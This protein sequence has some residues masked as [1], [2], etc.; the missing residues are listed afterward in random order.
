M[1]TACGVVMLPRMQTS[2][3]FPRLNW[4]PLLALLLMTGQSGAQERRVLHHFKPAD[5][6]LGDVHPFV[7]DG[8][9]FLYYLKPGT[10]DSALVRS[11]DWLH[12]TGGELTHSSTTPEDWMSPYYVL[13]VFHDPAA[14]V[15]RSFYGHS[16]GRM[17]S[18][19]SADLL[20]WS[21]APREYHIPP[22]DYYQRRRDP[23]VFWIPQTREYGCVMTTWMKGRPKETAGAVSLAVSPDLKQW[24]DIGP[25][26]DPGDIGEPECPQMFLLGG[27][28]Y[29]LASIYDRAVGAPVYWSSERPE[30][31]WNRK[32]TGALDGKDL[33]AA[34]I[35]MEGELPV[36]FGW[37]P[38]TASRPGRQPWGGHLALP[39]VV[40]SLGDGA[41][42]TR[43]P[44]RLARVFDKLPWQLRDDIVITHASHAVLGQW[45]NLA[46]E[47]MLEFATSETTVK[48][49]IPPLG[50]VVLHTSRLAVL[51][52][53]GECWS[54][55]PVVL[56]AGKPVTVQ[57]FVDGDIVELFVADRYSLAARLPGQKGGLR[58][59]MDAAGPQAKARGLRV[60]EW[61]EPR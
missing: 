1:S 55:L 39:R 34:Q 35:A 14:K 22:A 43:L 3:T 38:A 54:E 36:L 20:H 51:D 23:F 4:L 19:F 61:L 44:E 60:S 16:Q 59:V 56:P 6:A 9:C 15:Y 41:L 7:R 31:P 46:F 2:M 18:S 45:Q 28:W 58:L 21:C 25:I 24:T 8:E 47:C 49:K 5:H 50:E 42:G 30:G 12:W 32:P 10:Y 27:R 17:A 37:V 26:L 13:G 53:E 33:C 40:F 57:L 52:A 11:T 29:L 48:V